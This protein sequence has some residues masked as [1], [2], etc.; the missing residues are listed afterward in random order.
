MMGKSVKRLTL[1]AALAAMV[2]GLGFVSLDFGTF[3]FTFENFPILIAAVLFGP[4]DGFL[5]A[6][7]GEFLYQLLLYSVDFMTPL[8]IL[9]YVISGLFVGWISHTKKFRVVFWQVLLLFLANALLVSTVNTFSLY[10]YQLEVLGLEQHAVLVDLIAKLPLRVI[11]NV[12][13]A[14]VFAGIYIPLDKALSKVL[15]QLKN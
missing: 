10:I 12:L 5:V 2:F 6:L 9:P 3:K 15:K 14:I 4:L 7:V 8:W 1:D 13:K 11:T